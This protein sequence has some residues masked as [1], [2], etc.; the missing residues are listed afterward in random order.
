MQRRRAIR[1]DGMTRH[2]Y[3]LATLLL[4]SPNVEFYRTMSPTCMRRLLTAQ[5]FK[6]VAWVIVDN[7][8][9]N[10]PTSVSATHEDNLPTQGDSILQVA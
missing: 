3:C 9:L 4:L 8:Y 6:G 2:L 7:G 5:L 10:W 1:P